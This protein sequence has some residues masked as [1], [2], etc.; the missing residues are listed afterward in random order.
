M[1]EIV[2][3]KNIHFLENMYT[4]LSIIPMHACSN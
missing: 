4:R 1:W 3:K 2:D